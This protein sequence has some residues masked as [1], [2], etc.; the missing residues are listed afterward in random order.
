[1]DRLTDRWIEVDEE[2]VGK[3]INIWIERQLDRHKT[4]G[5]MNRQMD[6]YMNRELDGQ[7]DGSIDGI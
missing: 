4:D 7:M 5:P 2:Q 6:G 3:H 1:M